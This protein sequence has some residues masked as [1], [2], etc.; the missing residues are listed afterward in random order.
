MNQILVQEKIYVTP[1]LKRKKKMFRFEFFISVFLLCILSTYAIYAEYD[2]N[3]SEAVSKDLLDNINYGSLEEKIALSNNNSDVVRIEENA[4]VVILNKAL[5]N[6]EEISVE[7]ER[8]ETRPQ[9][10]NLY[11]TDGAGYTMIGEISIPSLNVKYPIILPDDLNTIDSLLKISVCKFHG[12]NPNEVGNLC[13]VGHNY[14]NTKFFSKVPTMEPGD[15]IEIKD[16]T[17]TTL[18]YSVYDKFLVYPDDVSCTSQIT[19]GKKEVTLIT[20]TNDNKQRY[21]IKAREI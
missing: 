21:I 5:E 7:Q 11:T 14:R 8:V 9:Q 6:N 19:D 12:A 15:I 20:C 13:I 4:L 17:G 3:K 1:E 2:R 16:L 10:E 18:R